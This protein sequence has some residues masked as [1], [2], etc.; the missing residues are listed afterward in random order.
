MSILSWL[1]FGMIVGIIANI[2]DPSP[3][4]GGLLGAVGLGIGGALIGGF[5]ASLIFSTGISGFNLSSFFIAVLG[6]LIL[7]FVE[8][9]LR[10]A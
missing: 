6:S 2:I 3:S 5:L 10:Q 4:R 9:S 7:L 1:I 8:R